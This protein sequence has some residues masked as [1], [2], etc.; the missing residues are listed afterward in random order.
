M[1]SAGT[2]KLEIGGINVIG[3]PITS[4]DYSISTLDNKLNFIDTTVVPEKIFYN[5]NEFFMKLVISEPSFLINH[6]LA[7]NIFS[8][9]F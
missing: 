8:M 6:P 7:R 4:Q 1:L 2:Y 5:F 9:K 3:N